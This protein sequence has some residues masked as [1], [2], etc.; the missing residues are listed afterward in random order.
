MTLTVGT[1]AEG[2]T[3]IRIFKAESELELWTRGEG[4][5][6]YTLTKTYPICAWS[7]RLGPKV[8]QGDRQAPEGFY[9][10][11]KSRLNPNSQFHLSFN[12]GYP[13]AYDRAHGR[14]GDFLMVHGNCVSWGCYAMTDDGI[15]EI[16]GAIETS[17]NGGQPFVRVHVFPFRMTEENMAAHAGS[18]W[19]DFWA[20]LKEGYDAF[21]GMGVPPDTIVRDKRYAFQ[22]ATF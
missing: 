16:Y 2:E 5:Y 21:E 22:V 4:E 3:F 20:N 7:G 10:V 8:K 15:E 1:V 12:L 9:W 17:L 14:T 19:S 18:E 13:N 6:E 11:D